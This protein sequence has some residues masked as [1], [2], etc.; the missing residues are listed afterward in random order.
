[1]CAIRR[2]IDDRDYRDLTGIDGCCTRP[3]IGHA[4]DA[5]TLP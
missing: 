5:A 2:G 4:L 1:M 3:S